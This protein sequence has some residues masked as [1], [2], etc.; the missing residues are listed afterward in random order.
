LEEQL[1]LLPAEPSL[2]LKLWVIYGT[3]VG[4]KNN[5]FHNHQ[6]KNKTNKLTKPKIVT[7]EQQPK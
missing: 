6:F 3:D 5:V 2:Q 4:G 7:K 1:M